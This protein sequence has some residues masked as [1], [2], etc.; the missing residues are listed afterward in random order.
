MIG[1]YQK[2]LELRPDNPI[3][4]GDLGF[5][6]EKQGKLPEA[7]KEYLTFTR[8]FLDNPEGYYGLGT[9]YLNENRPSNAIPPFARAE[10]LDLAANNL[11][12][13]VDARR[14]LGES[15]FRLKDW[16]KARNYFE[17]VY[18]SLSNDA[19]TNF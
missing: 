11:P 19:S 9:V 7:E 14:S 6:Y 5:A 18:P 13:V 17:L 16:G 10:Q 8:T 12:F 1:W 2:S 15:Y 4:R 3:A